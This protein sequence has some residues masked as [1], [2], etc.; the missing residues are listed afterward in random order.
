L[1]GRAARS[2]RKS[3]RTSASIPEVPKLNRASTGEQT[4][5]SPA[6][7]KE[8]FTR[9]GQPVRRWKASRRAA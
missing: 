3:S 7:L 5:G 2:R 9:S 6:T 1:A 4:I 8:V